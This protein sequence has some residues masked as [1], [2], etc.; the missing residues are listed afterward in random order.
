MDVISQNNPIGP[1][2]YVVGSGPFLLQ[3]GITNLYPECPISFQFTTN[4]QNPNPA[5]FVLNPQTGEITINSNDAGLIGQSLGGEITG[6]SSTQASQ[7]SEQ[8]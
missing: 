2:N 3:T 6:T 1:I 7:F 5:I 4:G 8:F